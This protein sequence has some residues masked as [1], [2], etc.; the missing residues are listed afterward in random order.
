MERAL[1]ILDHIGFQV[2]RVVLSLCAIVFAICFLL[3]VA[4][5]SGRYI[6]GY[7]LQR[8]SETVT[9]SFIW[10]FFLGAA[11]LY[12][13]SEDISVDALFELMP[14]RIKALWLLAI[15]LAIAVTMALIL[16]ETLKLIH[17]QRR[18]LTPL[19][20][21]PLGVQHAGLAVA[22]GLIVFSSLID[23]FACVVWLARGRRPAR[24]KLELID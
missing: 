23:A 19:L 15:S 3:L 9:I 17:V 4:D 24:R 20:R 5:I 13:R 11:A 16:Q 12:A 8:V 7:P 10:V 18:V 6:F 22:A 14:E 21:L 1:D 2:T